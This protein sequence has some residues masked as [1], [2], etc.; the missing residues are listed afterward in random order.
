VGCIT[1]LLVEPDSKLRRHF[2]H[3]LM[4]ETDLLLISR[5]EFFSDSHDPLE[6]LRCDV[7]L[8]DADRTPVLDVH[9]WAR[10]RLILPAAHIIALTDGVD[11][12]IL[13][14]ALAAG[15]T[16]LFRPDCEQAV[17][18]RAIYQ[19]AQGII[20]LD[21]SLI[22]HAK[23]VLLDPLTETQIRFGGLTIDLHLQEVTRWGRRIHLTPLEFAVLAY[24]AR[25]PGRMVSLSELLRAVWLTPP[26]NGGTLAQVYNCIKRIRQK[27]EPDVRHPRYLLSERGWGYWL[28]DPTLPQH[29]APLANGELAHALPFETD[30]LTKLIDN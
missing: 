24:L 7:L 26:A 27:I 2:E 23:K 17:L 3:I 11:D 1:V 16:G 18:V 12:R 14:S 10:I 21:R 9:L 22:E 19:A 6:L 20:S 13:E 5:P 15:L 8:L 25:Q 29:A 4:L 28:Q 30:L